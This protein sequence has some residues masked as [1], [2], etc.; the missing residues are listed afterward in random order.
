MKAFAPPTCADRD[1]EICEDQSLCP[2][3]EIQ[4]GTK[5]RIRRLNVSDELSQR[6]REI[7]FFEEQVLQLLAQRGGVICQ[8]D[9]C[10][11]GIGAKLAEGILVERVASSTSSPVKIQL[12]R[13]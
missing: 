13:Q 5:V 8:I 10:R 2:L 9:N 4:A 7:G 12:N 3:T 1:C 11:M 6:L